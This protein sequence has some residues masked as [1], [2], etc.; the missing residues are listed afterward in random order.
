MIK[1]Q[2]TKQLIELATYQT[3]GERDQIVERLNRAVD[4]TSRWKE[5]KQWFKVYRELKKTRK[6]LS[7]ELSS[8]AHMQ[9]LRR[10]CEYC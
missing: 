9:V 10:H 6:E 1:S 7:E 2:E 5:T 3:D 4:G 8:I